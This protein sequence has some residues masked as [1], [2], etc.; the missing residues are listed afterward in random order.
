VVVE[1]S[2]SGGDL[3][4]RLHPNG[5]VLPETPTVLSVVTASRSRSVDDPVATHAHALNS[6]TAVVPGAVLVEQIANIG[7]WSP[8]TEALG[9]TQATVFADLGH[10][11]AAS[12]VL[13]MAARAEVVVVVS[14]P[15][16]P[17]VVRMRERLT[18]LAIDLAR[19]R[20]T[21]PRLFP[22]LISLRR[23]A[24]GDVADLRAVL[25]DTAVKPFLADVGF[26]A[27]DPAAVRRLE[28]GDEP[29]GRL[30]RT[31]LMR[32]AAAV[33]NQLERVTASP[34]EAAAAPALR[35]RP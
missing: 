30:S 18:R 31:D 13:S 22:L 1:A 14:R 6:T 19:L 34:T 24:A 8:L 9:R 25:A 29:T 7:D 11:H 28:A 32:S 5:S 3:A 2:P 10:L 35:G 21:S 33:A 15:D 20:S 27:H 17:S 12:P 16:L 4:I 26:L 23:H